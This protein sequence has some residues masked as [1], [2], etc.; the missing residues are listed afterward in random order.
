MASKR[1]A[2]KQH[3]DRGRRG[4]AEPHAQVKYWLET[5][6]VEKGTM[7]G[8]G[9]NVRGQGMV[10]RIGPHAGERRHRGGAN[11]AV[12]QHG[13]SASARGERGA[14]KRREFVAPEG[15]SDRQGVAEDIDVNG[16]RAIHGRLFAREPLVVDAGP[17]SRPAPAAA[18]E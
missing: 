2:Q 7:A 10:E 17:T 6:L 1:R 8:F 14:Q 4:L 12:E 11:K 5:K 3:T 15:G 16:E 18:A 9:R 13:N